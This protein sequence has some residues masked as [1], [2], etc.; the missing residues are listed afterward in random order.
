ML[1]KATVAT[2]DGAPRASSVTRSSSDLEP[3]DP[4]IYVA[5]ECAALNL[6][7]HNHGL[8]GLKSV[9]FFLVLVLPAADIAEVQ[10]GVMGTIEAATFDPQGFEVLLRIVHTSFAHYA[11]VEPTC[12]GQNEPAPSGLLH[13]LRLLESILIHASP[14]LNQEL[15]AQRPLDP[16]IHRL[17]LVHPDVLRATFSMLASIIAVSPEMLQSMLSTISLSFSESATAAHT[18]SED[19]CMGFRD[20][21]CAVMGSKLNPRSRPDT[22]EWWCT[23]QQQMRASGLLDDLARFLKGNHKIGCLT[24]RCIQHQTL[25]L[26]RYRACWNETQTW[27]SRVSLAEPALRPSINVHCSR[28]SKH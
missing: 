24:L 4:E 23:V 3:L 15:L 27:S 6:V 1:L 10:S 8:V 5:I 25:T 12:H 2:S 7:R 19:K 20:F 16:L 18:V 17:G 22:Q 28:W 13:L 26:S 9:E 14:Q 11:S 21:V